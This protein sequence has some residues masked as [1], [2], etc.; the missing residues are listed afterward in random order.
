MLSADTCAHEI[1]HSVVLNS[2]AWAVA[3]QAPLSMAFSRQELWSGLQFPPPR[4]LPNPGIEPA[5]PELLHW[6]AD[7]LSMSHL[8]SPSVTTTYHINADFLSSD[9]EGFR[10]P[11]D[12]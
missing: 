4:D 6:Q 7:S 8:G 11:Q 1:S 2:D 3:H 12:L 10:K 5:F 9:L